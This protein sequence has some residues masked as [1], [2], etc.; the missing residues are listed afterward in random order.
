MTDGAI[1]ETVTWLETWHSAGGAYSIDGFKLDGQRSPAT[2]V[3]TNHHEAARY[4]HILD[5]MGYEGVYFRTT[6]L[7]TDHLPAPGKRGDAKA[8]HLMPGYAFDLDRT[9]GGKTKLSPGGPMP[10]TWEQWEKVRIAA[11]LPEYSIV[12]ESGGGFYG[13]YKFVE[14]LDVSTPEGL[15]RGEELAKQ[16]HALLKAWSQ[17]QGWWGLDS[18]TDLARVFGLPGTINRKPENGEPS[19]RHVISYGGPLYTVEQIEA[20]IASAPR[21]AGAKT[22]PAPAPPPR[23]AEG[24]SSLFDGEGGSSLFG[25]GGGPSYP[26]GQHDWEWYR[27]EHLDPALAEARAPTEGFNPALNH[28]AYIMGKGIPSIFTEFGVRAKLA[29]VIAE[30]W[31]NE[32]DYDD[33]GTINSG[34]GDG[35]ADPWVITGAPWKAAEEQAAQAAAEVDAA[36]AMIA[37]MLS[38]SA[39]SEVPPPR[40]LIHGLLQFDS[41]SWIIGAPG[42]KK[43]FVALDMAARVARGE[44]T[45]QGRRVNAADVVMIV[46]E[47]AGGVGKRVKAWRSRYGEVEGIHFLP[48][49]VQSTERTMGSIHLGAE[50]RVLAAA[51]EKLAASARER[52]RGLLVI[53]DTQA[54]VTVGLNENSSEEMG[55]YIEAVR[56][57]RERTGACV[58]TVHHTGRAG[59]DARGS[60]AI[61]GAQTTELK[62]KTGDAEKPLTGYL[63]VEKQKDMEQ[64]DQIELGFDVVELGVDADGDPVNSLVLAEAS[65]TAFKR[66][67]VGGEAG[68]E[69]EE[70]LTTPFKGRGAPEHWIVQRDTRARW[71]HWIV[72]ALVDTVGT[73]GLTESQTRG[74]IEEKHGKVDAS[75]WRKAWQKVTDESGIWADVVVSARGERWTVDFVRVAEESKD[76]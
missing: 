24:G 76:K 6:T 56:V 53:I 57:I 5:G 70:L 44:S 22:K 12:E 39:V 13:M 26:T 64:I 29:E 37:S 1:A 48:R 52:G 36:D 23:P 21:P 20:A 28:L 42:S 43:S 75:T 66:A 18:T 55:H 49:P 15:A 67:W 71:Q 74:L 2:Q 16:A 11:G 63:K 40:Y 32:P 31:E 9:W 47:G 62:V 7:H 50:W 51:C 19:R 60:S 4:A 45:W 10:E 61:D 35:M 30:V 34:L 41:E 27:K 65:S 33:E 3:F 14:P 68:E 25:G 73:L 46:A 59:G 38:F 72:Q 17:E 54:R 58:L 8:S 69:S